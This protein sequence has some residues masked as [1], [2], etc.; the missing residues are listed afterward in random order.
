MLAQIREDLRENYTFSTDSGILIDNDKT[1]DSR[2][3][4]QDQFQVW[5]NGAWHNIEGIDFDCVL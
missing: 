4:D 3:N 5:I 1:Y 2:Y